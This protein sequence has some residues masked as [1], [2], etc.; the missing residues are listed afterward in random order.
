MTGG[1]ALIWVDDDGPGVAA[2]DLSAIFTRLFSSVDR[3]GRKV[4]TGL[5]LAIVAELVASMGGDVRAESPL[6]PA[7]GTG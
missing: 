4:G 6:G 3:P 5:G 1:T 2:D 7:G